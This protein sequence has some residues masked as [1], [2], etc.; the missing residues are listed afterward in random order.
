MSF[1]IKS[2]KILILKKRDVEKYNYYKWK[3][4]NAVNDV[5]D[6]AQTSQYKQFTI[7]EISL[8]KHACFEMYFCISVYVTLAHAASSLKSLNHEIN[9]KKKN[10]PTK[11]SRGK[12]FD[13]RNT[14]EQTFRTHEYP[15]ENFGPRKYPR[16]HGSTMALNPRDPRQHRPTKFSTLFKNCISQF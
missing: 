6:E 4:R 2:E 13:P 7:L 1:T 5:V 8:E 12:N 15:R 10:G 14:H 11:Y 16:R 3:L 9:Y